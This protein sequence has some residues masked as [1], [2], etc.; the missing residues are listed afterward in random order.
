M[1]AASIYKKRLIK[2]QMPWTT[3]TLAMPPNL[4]NPTYSANY[5]SKV[6]TFTAFTES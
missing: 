1:M 6:T 5:S 2:E 4:I 3:L